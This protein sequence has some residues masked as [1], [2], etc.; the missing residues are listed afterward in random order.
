M[1]DA[2]QPTLTDVGT[3]I[4]DTYDVQLLHLGYTVCRCLSCSGSLVKVQCRL[5][6]M[7]LTYCNNF[8]AALIIQAECANLS[9]YE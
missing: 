5:T 4:V 8:A 3:H 2:L 9:R 6:G 1:S 7:K